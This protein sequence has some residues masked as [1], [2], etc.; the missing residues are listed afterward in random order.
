MA[1]TCFVDILERLLHIGKDILG[2]F[3]FLHEP[4]RFLENAYF[5]NLKVEE[6]FW[7]NERRFNL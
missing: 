2:F 1:L 4:F 7:R 5:G 6:L 3:L